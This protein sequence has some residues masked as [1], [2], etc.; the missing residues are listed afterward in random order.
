MG[1]EYLDRIKEEKE[2]EI[3]CPEYYWWIYDH[4]FAISFYGKEWKERLKEQV[5]EPNSLDYIKRYL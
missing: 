2:Y 4:D 3:Q 5:L 1:E